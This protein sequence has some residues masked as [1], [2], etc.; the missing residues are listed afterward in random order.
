MRILWTNVFAI[1]LGVFGIVI[2]VKNRIEITGFLGT[3]K[4][5]GPGHS[6]E[7][8]TVGLIAI[9]LVLVTI[10]ALVKILTHND[11]RGQ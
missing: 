8:Q 4:D 10:V 9:G 7:E 11:R 3:M 2:L 1:V 5:I 6:P